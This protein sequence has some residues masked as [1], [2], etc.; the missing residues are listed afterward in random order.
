[1]AML[2]VVILNVVILNVVI[3]NVVM[4]SVVP[5]SFMTIRLNFDCKNKTNN[6]R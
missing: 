2:S 4:L 5:S 3:L 1:M 6:I